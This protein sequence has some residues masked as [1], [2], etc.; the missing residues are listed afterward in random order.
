MLPALRFDG[1]HSHVHPRL[2]PLALATATFLCS[3]GAALADCVLTAGNG[4]VSAPG[5]GARLTCQAAGGAQATAIVAAPGSTDV[6]VVIENGASFGLPGNFVSVGSNSRMTNAATLTTTG[7]GS[8]GLIVNGDTSTVVNNG[9]I[10]TTGQSAASV[11]VES[12]TGNTVINNGTLTSGENQGS[13]VKF[14]R[15][16][17]GG[18][19]FIN[20]GTVRSTVLGFGNSATAVVLL[21]QAG[22]STLAINRGTISSDSGAA[23]GAGAGNDRFENYGTLIR[24]DGD[25]GSVILGTGNDTYVIGGNSTF[26]SYIDGGRDTDTVAFG[27][28]SGS[29]DVSEIDSVAGRYRRFERLEKIGNAGWTLT[30]TNSAALPVAV[31]SG[32]LTLN[33]SMPNSPATVASGATLTGTGT[34]GALDIA[35]GGILAPG[36][37]AALGTF[38]ASSA[39]FASGSRFNVRVNDRGE[40]DRVQVNGT[41]TINGGNVAVDV[42]RGYVVNT[43][44]RIL[45]ATSLAGPRFQ[46]VT[47]SLA[48]LQPVLSYDATN[49]YVTLQRTAEE[50]DDPSQPV[51]TLDEVGRTWNQISTGLALE[52]QSMRGPLLPIVLAQPTIPEVLIALDL[53]SGEGYATAT[54]LAAADTET[55]HRALLTRLRTMDGFALGAAPAPA[56]TAYA[57]TPAFPAAPRATGQTLDLWGQAFGNWSR[58]SGRTG[59]G[60]ASIDSN[61]GG[62]ILGAETTFDAVWR[63]G[64]AGAYT[65]TRFDLGGRLSSGTL[66]SYHAALYGSGAWGGFALRGGATYTRHDLDMSRRAAF[67]GFSDRAS[68][69]L[70]FDSAGAFAEI[71]YPVLIGRL[72]AEPVANLSYVHTGKGSFTEDGGSMALRG[73]TQAFDN[74]STILGLRLSG[75]LTDDGRLKGYSLIG[76]RH[77]FGDRLPMTDNQ[78]LAGGD[79]FLIVGTPMDRD[80]LIVETGLDWFVTPAATLGL[81]YDGRYGETSN[82]QSVRGQFTAQF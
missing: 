44:Y 40:S 2:L 55:I 12:G 50:P 70:G 11:Y 23:F 42:T 5:N 58:N 56:P 6:Q 39:T 41:A 75:D 21:S 46:G 24:T 68:G 19:T 28:D 9:T 79:P 18:A 81:R 37:G 49:V 67:T 43:P 45:T 29:L 76:W 78:F 48:L 71:G 16:G 60:L 30:G 62:L 57:A 36:G 8:H 1:L 4:T 72:T 80:S 53:L 64:M 34:V 33:A 61:T 51:V 65:Q 52:S 20:N 82:S 15:G 17:A 59:L 47:A 74:A 54:G 32:V 7:A 31:S 63:V 25:F 35:S 38:T 10:G 77:A 13:G 27:V 69:G 26:D 3:T 14:E 66:D 73:T 22:E